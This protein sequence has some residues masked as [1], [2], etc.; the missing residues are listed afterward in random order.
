MRPCW[1]VLLCLIVGCRG[2]VEPRE[3]LPDRNALVA[4]QLIIHSSGPMP[5]HHRLFDDLRAQ[6][7]DML[8]LLNLAPSDEP[9]HVYL[10]DDQTPLADFMSRHY[11]SFPARRAFFV[12]SDTQLV[13][14]AQWGDRVAEDLRHEVAHGYLHSV[15]R[16]VP[17]WI[18]EGL[19]EYF[20]VP[21]GHE[22]INTPHV[23]LLVEKL[24]SEGW[25]P[26]LE[27][28]EGLE[29]PSEM[30][31]LE[32]AEAWAW[33]HWLLET[34]SAERADLQTFVAA[35]AR[36]GRSEPLSAMLRRRHASPEQKLVQHLD[37][38]AQRST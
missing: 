21:R 8:T 1:G 38:L 34:E 19:A 4:D 22:G 17:L 6:R 9:I 23:Q 33:T 14:Y 26:N 36:Q 32:Y 11:P 27:R 29:S 2:F 5:Q 20:E 30:T 16:N 28:L 18:D 37:R 7:S 10:F 25:R 12:E 15:A 24:L 35:L 3:P 31:Q 13:V